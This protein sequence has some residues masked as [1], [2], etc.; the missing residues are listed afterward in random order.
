MG[1]VRGVAAVSTLGKLS[2]FN[3]SVA[4]ASIAA[5]AGVSSF[6]SSLLQAVREAAA[7]TKARDMA[8]KCCFFIL[9]NL[10]IFKDSQKFENL[11]ILIFQI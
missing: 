11:Y 1:S 5:G 4:G 7:T 3:V 10:V 9:V 8:L 6:F 2:V